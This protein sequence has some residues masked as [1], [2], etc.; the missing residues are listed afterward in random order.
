MTTT[1]Q[2]KS[3][4][5][6][7][8]PGTY[9]STGTFAY[10]PPPPGYPPLF[11]YPPPVDGQQPDANGTPYPVMYPPGVVYA[12]FP[13]QATPAASPALGTTGRPKRKQVKMACTNCAAACKRCDDARPCERCQK[14]GIAESCVDGQRKE[15]KKGIK[16]GP[17][18]R[19]SKQSVDSAHTGDYAPQSTEGEWTQPPGTA[20]ALPS[21]PHPP[22]GYYSFYYPPSGTYSMQEGQPGAE[23]TTSNGHPGPPPMMPLYVGGFP[24]YPLTLPPGA[25]FQLPPSASYPPPLPGSQPLTVEAGSAAQTDKKAQPT[26]VNPADVSDP[27]ANKEP[28]GSGE[29]ENDVS[30][31]NSM[32][33]D[34]GSG[35]EA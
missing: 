5:N 33:D 34:S 4:L 32:R 18:K 29:T 27:S 22:E 17:Y 3:V 8:Q 13:P 16:R 26:G 12:A 28:Q 23:G 19:K 11:A 9:P 1:E 2:P 25:V 14:Y 24:P 31:A 6:S 20:P 15:R 30:Q 7:E 21:F 10:P 35:M